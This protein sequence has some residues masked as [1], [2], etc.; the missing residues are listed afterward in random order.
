MPKRLSFVYVRHSIDIPVIA[1][2][3]NY[4]ELFRR[5][6]LLNIYS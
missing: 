3:Y 1:Y 2:G 6:L 5:R 4:A